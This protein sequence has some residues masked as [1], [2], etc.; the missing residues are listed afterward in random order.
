MFKPEDSNIAPTKI[1]NENS[2]NITK[3]IAIDN[4]TENPELPSKYSDPSVMNAKVQELLQIKV[5]PLVEE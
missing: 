5:K 3:A 1:N 2:L 4:I